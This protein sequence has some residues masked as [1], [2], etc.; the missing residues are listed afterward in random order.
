V[1]NR[2]S[3]NVDKKNKSFN[4]LICF[5]RHQKNKRRKRKKEEIK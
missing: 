1:K 3:F 2:P 5:L 4:L